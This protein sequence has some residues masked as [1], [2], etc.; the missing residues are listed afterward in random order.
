MLLP[1]ALSQKVARGM[2]RELPQA[3]PAEEE[4]GGGALRRDI[5]C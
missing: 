3:M 1:L 2:D 5:R 4:E